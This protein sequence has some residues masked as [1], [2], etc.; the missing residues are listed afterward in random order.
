M[1]AVM[2]CYPFLQTLTMKMGYDII[3]IEDDKIPLAGDLKNFYD[4][5][6]YLVPVILIIIFIGV[7]ITLYILSCR[8]YQASIKKLDENKT[9][10]CGYRRNRLK[11]TLA[12]LEMKRLD[13]LEFSCEESKI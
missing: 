5:T 4:I 7:L 6:S 1:K 13:E 10:Y 2:L 8:R 11:E 9:S 3:Q 12:E